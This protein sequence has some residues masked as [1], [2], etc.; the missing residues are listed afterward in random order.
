MVVVSEGCWFD[1]SISVCMVDYF[2]IVFFYLIIVGDKFCLYSF[3]SRNYFLNFEFI[4][5]VVLC[6]LVGFL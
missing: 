5:D 3:I 6:Y 4:L 1:F 2:F